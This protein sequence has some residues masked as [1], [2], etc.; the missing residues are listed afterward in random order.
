MARKD[1][2]GG[3]FWFILSLVVIQQSL[4][5]GLGDL[6]T[7]GSGLFPMMWG[8]SLAFLAGGIW[9]GTL[10]RAKGEAQKERSVIGLT[11]LTRL[12]V[13]IGILLAFWFCFP[14]LGFF[15]CSFVALFFLFRDPQH[16]G[17]FA[18]LLAAAVTALTGFLLFHVLLM[19][20]FPRGPWGLM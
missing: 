9:I 5:L 1:F 20:Q 6:H 15:F 12:G 3:L 4:S 14:R 8:V 10:L 7:P 2:I 19:I 16:K 11:S 18:A 13:V 17:V